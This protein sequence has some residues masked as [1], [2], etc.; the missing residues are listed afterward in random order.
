MGGNQKV[1]KNSDDFYCKSCDYVTVKKSNCNKH[2]LTSKNPKVTKS[3]KSSN[4]NHYA[5]KNCDNVY[6]KKL[7]N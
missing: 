6:N 7:Q 2:I 1:A 5:C 4:L 3:S